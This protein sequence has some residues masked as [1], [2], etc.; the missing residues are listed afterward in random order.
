VGWCLFRTML[1]YIPGVYVGVLG[2][3]PAQGVTGASSRPRAMPNVARL[4][5]CGCSGVSSIPT[6]VRDSMRWNGAYYARLQKELEDIMP[7]NVDPK[8]L[9]PA[10]LES[11]KED[12][13]ACL[14]NVRNLLLSGEYP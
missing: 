8:T 5:Y 7:L 14:E 12:V 13:I 4:S 10:E 3:D 9:S 6:P 11:R 1:I 2:R